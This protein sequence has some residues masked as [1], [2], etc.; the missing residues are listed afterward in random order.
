LGCPATKCST[1]YGIT[2]GDHLN[3]VS[4]DPLTAKRTPIGR[5]RHPPGNSV[6]VLDT[7]KSIY[8]YV[9][10]TDADAHKLYGLSVKTGEIVTE[11]ILAPDAGTIVFIEFLLLDP[12][13][14]F[15][16]YAVGK[17]LQIPDLYRF[18]VA[19]NKSSF[20]SHLD[21]VPGSSEP[22]YGLDSTHD[23]IFLKVES[24][25]AIHVYKLSTGELVN[26]I[27]DPFDTY[28]FNWDPKTGLMF[29]FGAISHSPAWNFTRVVVSIDGTS[30]EIKQLSELK[31]YAGIFEV[32]E[33]ALDPEARTLTSY[34]EE[35][36]TSD[37]YLVSVNIDTGAII[38]E[39]LACDHY[40]ED[41]EFIVPVGIHYSNGN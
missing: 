34:F 14:G 12:K 32:N 9:T 35:R 5:D 28:T 39:A 37:Y 1:I 40:K 3:F 18:D 4:I 31:K 29:G 33:G 27:Q 36:D 10:L 8:Y 21:T 17:I 23:L 19:T 7:K 16:Y 6:S 30:G 20:V 22:A 15:L 11:V 13:T 38:N 26:V 24:E 2:V 25:H 41:C